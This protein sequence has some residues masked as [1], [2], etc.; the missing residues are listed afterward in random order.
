MRRMKEDLALGVADGSH[1]VTVSAIDLAGNSQA[2]SVNLTVDTNPFSPTG[3]YGSGPLIG[4]IGTI[5][6]GVL[7]VLLK[8]LRRGGL[9]PKLS[10][11]RTSPPKRMEFLSAEEVAARI[12]ELGR[13]R[14]EG[15]ITEEEFQ[16][17]KEELLSRF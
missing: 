14:D 12:R 1:T 17:K 11:R 7:L 4:L 3:P 8:L 2:V 13:R 16:A 15:L 10:R 9:P 6:V 5:V